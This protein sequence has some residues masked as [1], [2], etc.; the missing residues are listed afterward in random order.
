MGDFIKA[1]IQ[2]VV[3]YL[4]FFMSAHLWL[5][6]I[7]WATAFMIPYIGDLNDILPTLVLGASGFCTGIT[8]RVF[9]NQFRIEGQQFIFFLLALIAYGFFLYTLW[10]ELQ[11]VIG[12]VTVY[13]PMPLDSSIEFWLLAMPFVNIL[14][15]VFSSFFTLD[16]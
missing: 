11:I 10:V 4:L 16:D 5:L 6:G 13:R 1:V 9:M 15:M 12:S 14:G 3:A 8:N 7:D 2:F